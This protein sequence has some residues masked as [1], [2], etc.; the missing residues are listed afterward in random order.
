MLTSE[1]SIQQ[2]VISYFKFGGIK[3]GTWIFDC[4]GAG[5]PN[6]H[7]V[8]GSTV[9]Y[10]VQNTQKYLDIFKDFT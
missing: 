7:I 6:P 1:A 3:S 4:Y 2:E 9:F 5:A 10:F 8:Q